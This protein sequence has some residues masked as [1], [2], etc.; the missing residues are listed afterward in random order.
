MN[1]TAIKNFAIWARKKLIGDISFQAGLAGVTE[2][3]IANEL[4]QS[5]GNVKFY[6]IGT[7]DPVSIS[8]EKIRMRQRLLDAIREK[9]KD[10]SYPDAFRFV[11]EKDGHLSNFE[12][13]R[14]PDNILNEEAIRVLRKTGPWIPAQN[15]GRSVR[16]NFCMPVVFRIK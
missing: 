16:C 1:K 15:R 7:K 12:V 9:E 5:S 6:D 3:G 14:T 11:V 8:G 4:P 10:G 13:L 2:S